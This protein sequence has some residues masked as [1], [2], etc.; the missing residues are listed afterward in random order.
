[1]TFIDLDGFLQ[2]FKK[3]SSKYTLSY[4]YKNTNVKV[5]NKLIPLNNYI[6][7][8]KR[9]KDDIDYL[10]VLIKDKYDYLKR[11]YNTSLKIE[12]S[13]LT[14]KDKAPM[15]N[16]QFNNNIEINYKNVIRNMHNEDILQNTSSGFAN[17]PTYMQV[18]VDLYEHDIID[19]KL[20][21][22]SAL[23]YI[24]KGRLGSVFSSFYFRA[25]IMSPYLV[26]SLNKSLLKGTKIF[27]PTLGWSSYCF[28]FLECDEVT[29]YVGTDVIP[30]VCKKTIDFAS[31]YEDKTIKIYCK[32]SEDLLENKNFMKKYK[33][34]FNVIFFSPP[35]YKL[36][37]YNS[38]NQSTDKYNTYD[39]WLSL[40]WEQTMKLC[41]HVLERGGRICYIISDYGTNNT[42]EQF[43]LIKDMCDI[44]RKYFSFKGKQTMYN[45]NVNVTKHK[46]TDEQILFFV[47]D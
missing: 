25:S 31:N 22:P 34:H 20:L 36:E 27:T 9:N 18:I 10:Y 19:Y 32:P 7:K 39:K 42:G 5:G 2:K 6:E 38:N 16:K 26:Y 3:K 11:F 41:Y 14:M 23:A 24:K 28:G 33:Q 47:K 37:L 8:K 40:Y 45:K 12:P 13:M 21:T 43:N 29:E 46:N 30:S 15:E 17:T 44:S 1:M 35:Y 4:F